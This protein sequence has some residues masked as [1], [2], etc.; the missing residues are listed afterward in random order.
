MIVADIGKANLHANTTEKHYTVL[1]D[2]YG[3]LSSEILAFHKGLYGLKSSGARFH[4]H[5]NDMFRKI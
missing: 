2:D 3:E 4:E 5:L 1:E